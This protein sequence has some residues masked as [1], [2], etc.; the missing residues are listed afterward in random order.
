M[1][2]E[3]RKVKTNKWKVKSEKW[4]VKCKKWKVKSEMWNVKCE[5]WKWKTK[6][7]KSVMWNVYDHNFLNIHQIKIIFY[8][9]KNA[10][11]AASIAGI[12]P[13]FIKINILEN[14]WLCRSL[15]SEKHKSKIT[16]FL[17]NK[18]DHI[19][20]KI[21]YRRLRN[22]KKRLDRSSE[23]RGVGKFRLTARNLF[24]ICR[25]TVKTLKS[26]ARKYRKIHTKK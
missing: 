18:I 13:T 14:L 24:Y 9:M 1:K 12:I 19:P 21:H 22:V 8:T 5:K 23:P 4:K 10:D 25:D 3:K 15:P 7:L 16:F 17:K 2:S 26:L 11:R 6:K 20:S